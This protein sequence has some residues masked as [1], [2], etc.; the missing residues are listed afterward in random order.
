MMMREKHGS[1][2]DRGAADSYYGREARPHYYPNGTYI[3]PRVNEDKMSQAEVK[4]YWA[5]YDDN[6]SD[7]NM[8]KDHG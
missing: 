1:P 8:R 4:E 3:D 2:Y 6:E 5:G 7:M